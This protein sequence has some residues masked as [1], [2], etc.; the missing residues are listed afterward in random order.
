MGR[1]GVGTNG[2]SASNWAPA[3]R[4]WSD[5]E[6]VA[7]LDTSP[8]TPGHVLLITKVHVATV[9]DL[10]VEAP[11]RLF[12][13]VRELSR[14]VAL[15]AGASHAGI[16]VEGFG[17]SHAHVHLVPIWRAGDLDPCRQAKAT[18]AELRDAAD[19]LRAAIGSAGLQPEGSLA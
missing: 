8:I 18:E 1:S 9:D 5:E 11:A 10:S 16:A 7:F 12:T 4:V 19:R 14:P 2:L 15:A 3:H 6:H 17:V 13:R